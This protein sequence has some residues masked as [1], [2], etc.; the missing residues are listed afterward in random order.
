MYAKG[1]HSFDYEPADVVST[2]FHFGHI[3]P[4]VS[5]GDHVKRGDPIA[6]VFFD[7]PFTP[8]PAYVVVLQMSDGQ[9]YQFSPCELSDRAAFCGKC[10]PG[11]PFNC[12]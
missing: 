1:I 6:A 9:A 5:E 4:F 11:T 8:K 10:A 12:P 7:T 2:A 3:T